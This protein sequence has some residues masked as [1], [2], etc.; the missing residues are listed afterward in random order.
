MPENAYARAGSDGRVEQRERVLGVNDEITRLVVVRATTCEP[1][2]VPRV[3]DLPCVGGCGDDAHLG[4][5]IRVHTHLPIVEDET[6][7]DDHIG[8]QATAP[9]GPSAAHAIPAVDDLGAARRDE[10]TGRDHV[11][12]GEQVAAHGLIEEG[13]IE[14]GIRA[15][16]HAPSHSGIGARE[17]FDDRSLF[18]VSSPGHPTNAASACGTHLPAAGHSPMRPEVGESSRSCP[19]ANVPPTRGRVRWTGSHQP[20]GSWREPPTTAVDRIGD[21]SRAASIPT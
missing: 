18:A 2:R 7:T 4:S 8:V 16:H 3:E 19:P 11:E 17:D 6:T 20:S 14:A 1:G 12:V 21:M 5:S 13:R 10:P 15:D 9:E